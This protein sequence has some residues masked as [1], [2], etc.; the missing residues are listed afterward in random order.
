MKKQIVL[1]TGLALLSTSAFATKARMEALGQDADRGSF[2]ID[3]SRNVFRN[4]AHVNTMKNY[5]ITE[6]GTD[7]TGDTA[8]APQAEGGVFKEAGNFAWGL[9]MGNTIGHQTTERT[10]GGTTSNANFQNRDNELNLFLGGDMGVE[11]GVNLGYSN[12]KSKPATFEKTQSALG[13]GLGVVAGDL[14]A[15]ANLDLSDKSEGAVVAGDKWEADLG[16]HLGVTYNVSGMTVFVEYDKTGSERSLVSDATFKPEQ[17]DTEIEVGVGRVYEH[18]ATSRMFAE[19]SYL[20]RKAE[21]KTGAT[22]T[23]E[24]KTTGLPVTFGF[25][26]D[27]T[28]WLTLRGSVTQRL[29]F[30]NKT[31]T[32]TT[33]AA[34][35][36]NTVANTADVAAGAT[37]NFG[38]LKVD[39]FIGNDANTGETGLLT[40][41]HLMTRVSVHYWF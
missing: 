17:S 16:M 19:V 27:A 33:G 38:K 15:W 29:P 22:T 37:L 32:T 25:E 39:G 41:D 40:L 26:T 20:N 36:E 9:Y 5:I 21:D 12:N 13:L 7:G 10:G 8:A 34:A 2:Y 6:W 35:T 4:A 28:S 23:T 3:D 11:W 24:V 14:A 30:M 31:E 1:A 18:S